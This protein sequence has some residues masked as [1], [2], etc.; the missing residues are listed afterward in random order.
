MVVSQISSEAVRGID[1]MTY[2]LWGFLYMLEIYFDFSG[3]SDI[4]IGLCKTFGFEIEG[5]FN[6]PYVSRSITEFWRR[7]HISLGNWFRE[8][9]YIPLGGNRKGNVYINLFI[10][11]LLTG[12]WHGA[13]WTFILWG[14]FN[15]ILVVIERYAK[16]KEIYRRFPKAIKWFITLVLIYLLWILFMSPT[17]NEALDIYKHLLGIVHTEKVNFTYQY[18]LTTKT[19]YIA[20]IGCITAVLGTNKRVRAIVKNID[21]ITLGKYKIGYMFKAVIMLIVFFTSILFIVNSTYKPFLYF[22]F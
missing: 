15:G 4:A 17:V 12:V 13:N 3:Y 14:I 22:Q 2:F 11:F 5:N 18:Y 8:Y 6:Y 7:W 20:W 19:S 10:V 21:S 9:V 1:R 16:N